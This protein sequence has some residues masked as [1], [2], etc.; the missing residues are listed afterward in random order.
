[1]NILPST[2]C[3]DDEMEEHLEKAGAELSIFGLYGLLFGCLAAPGIVMPSR[4]M[5][6]IFGREG[7]DFKTMEQAQAAM[8]NIMA[9]WN[10]LNGWTPETK[11]SPFPK[12]DYSCDKEGFL[13]RIADTLE[14]ADSFFK[15]LMLGGAGKNDLPEDL[16]EDAAQIE[17]IASVMHAQAQLLEEGGEADGEVMDKTI[18]S[19]D[20]GESVIDAC[21]MNI[22][23]GLKEERMRHAEE[24]RAVDSA[25]KRA[26]RSAGP[27]ISRNQPCPCGS[28]RKYKRCCGMTH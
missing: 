1:M 11:V 17:R 24:M 16:R 20:T 10:R 7:G 6:E 18:E 4:L 27:K 25:L 12:Y 13:H 14:L 3:G 8:G 9:L 21:M 26:G 19:L 15:G 23:E 28:G 2:Y 5:P 22:H